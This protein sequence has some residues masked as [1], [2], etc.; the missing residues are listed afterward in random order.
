MKGFDQLV[1]IVARLRGPGGCPWDQAQTPETFRPYVIEEAYE[2]VDAIDRGDPADLKKELGDVMFQLVI[3]AR[4]AEDAGWFT[5]DDVL[6]GICEKM[7]RRHPHVFDPDYD[8]AVDP[9]GVA[10][11]ERRKAKE[12]GARTSALDGV[13]RGMPA[14]LRAHRVSEK[15]SMVGF[16]WPDAASVRQKVVEELGELDEAL[17][18]SDDAHILEEYGDLLF[19]LV[20]LG[21]HLP[22]GAEAAL[23]GATRKFERRF[24]ALESALQAEGGS[25]HDTSPEA[26]EARWQALKATEESR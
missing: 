22:H 15:A 25:I 3:L 12:R 16:D 2:I 18:A 4:M 9:S 8:H 20:N 24:R 17:A 7:I 21:R 1:Q 23:R 19:A 5:L 13:P 11:W 10:A 26:L 6:A 14:L